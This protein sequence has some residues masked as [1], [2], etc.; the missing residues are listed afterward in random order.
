VQAIKSSAIFFG[1]H[2]FT[3]VRKPFFEVSFGNSLALI[4]TR[5]QTHDLNANVF[6][7]NK[8]NQL[9]IFL[10]EIDDFK[11]VHPYQKYKF[12]RLARWHPLKPVG[13]PLIVINTE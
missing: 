8:K 10:A 3:M 9:I 5:T 1:N 12:L 11:Q 2:D 13:R 6:L 4:F 7:W